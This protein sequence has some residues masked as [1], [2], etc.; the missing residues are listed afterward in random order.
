LGGEI[1]LESTLG[2][3]STFRLKFPKRLILDEAGD[4]L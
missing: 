2:E 4:T 3:G 1:T